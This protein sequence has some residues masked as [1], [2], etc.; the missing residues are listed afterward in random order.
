M[1][2]IEFLEKTQETLLG[3]HEREREKGRRRRK[4]QNWLKLFIY[5]L[6]QLGF[7]DYK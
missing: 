7:K 4:I 6:T 3:F 1:R 2:K 5:S